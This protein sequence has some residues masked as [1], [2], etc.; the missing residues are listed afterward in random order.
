VIPSLGPVQTVFV[1]R[2]GVIN[3]DRPGSVRSWQEFAFL[4]GALDALALLTR[5]GVRV[6]IITNQS[7]VGRGNLD[8]AELDTIHTRM[9]AA[10]R[11]HGGEI[12]A[13][14]VCPHAPDH[15]CTCRK[16][17]PG[18]LQ[19]ARA[20]FELTLADTVLIGDY[21]SDL[22][23][24]QR[25]GVPSILVL[26]GRTPSWPGP[27]LPAGCVAVLPDLWSAA[28]A[29]VAAASLTPSEALPA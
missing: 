19:E 7:W 26:S 4:P 13:L 17:L 10:I 24:A 15:G 5:S 14:L 20:R 25:A 2:D 3:V 11:E 28:N 23:A 9:L 8:P 22:E 16:P 21:W 12:A 29:L 6:I 18:L 1:D 27:E